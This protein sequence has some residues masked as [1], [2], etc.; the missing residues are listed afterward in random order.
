MFRAVPGLED[1][2]SDADAVFLQVRELLGIPE[3]AP[4]NA[5]YARDCDP[6]I[7]WGRLVRGRFQPIDL[8]DAVLADERY[9]FA[10]VQAIHPDLAAED[11]AGGVDDDPDADGDFDLSAGPSG[12]SRPRSAKKSK[13]KDKDKGKGKE[14]DASKK[15]SKGK[16]VRPKDVKVEGGVSPLFFFSFSSG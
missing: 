12:G 16:S 10:R 13:G 7:P 11:D 8:D 4:P 14:S 3:N 15:P 5:A 9:G 6:T 2:L 1:Q